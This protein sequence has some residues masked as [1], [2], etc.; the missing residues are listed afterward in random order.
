MREARFHHAIELELEKARADRLQASLAMLQ[1]EIEDLQAAI[2][3]LFSEL[4]RLQEERD[5]ARARAARGE[6]GR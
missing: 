5:E 6:G 1:Q 3:V 2:R 4:N